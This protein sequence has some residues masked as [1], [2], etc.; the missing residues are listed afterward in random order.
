MNIDPVFKLKDSVDVYTFPGKNNCIQIQFYKINTRE[1][2]TIKVDPKVSKLLANLD[3]ISTIPEI[4]QKLNYSYNTLDSNELFNYL[5][6]RGVIIKVDTSDPDD[7]STMDRYS[8]QIN[9][10]DDL[11]DT[12]PGLSTQKKLTQK[13]VVILG[14]GAIGSSIAI[15]LVRSGVENITL[16]DYKRINL[17]HL[18]RHLYVTKNTISQYKTDALKA[19]LLKINP[20]CHI[21]CINTKIKPNSNTFSFIHESADLVVNT[22]DEPYIGHITLKIGRDLWEKDI[23]M[24][25]AGGFDAHLMST[26]ELIAKG[27]SPCADCCSNTFK[28]ALK[29]WKPTY[30]V[31]NDSLATKSICTSSKTKKNTFIL[32][33]AGG[34]ASQALFSASYASINIINYLIENHKSSDKFTSRGE[35]ILNKGKMTWI[36][37]ENQGG[38]D[39][40]GNR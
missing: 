10:F 40:C 37:L 6:S 21:K 11:L 31:E 27:I 34:L 25:V 24:Y 4:M 28:Q 7:S 17:G 38:C 15:H 18:T 12:Q 20:R 36:Q 30:A 22:A 39:V 19:Y 3:G 13:D 35:Y 32:G 8:R 9:Y 29:N 16:V 5:E 26:G 14:T 33:G 2:F 1:K 23:A